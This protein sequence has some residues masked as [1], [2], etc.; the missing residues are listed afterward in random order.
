[1][2]H[3][4]MHI[5]KGGGELNVTFEDEEEEDDED[6]DEEGLEDDDDDDDDS[7]VSHS[8]IHT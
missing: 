7:P 8:V 3:K 2:I 6:E 1:M 5:L 4:L